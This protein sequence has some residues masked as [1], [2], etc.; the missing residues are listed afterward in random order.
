M[1]TTTERFSYLNV[2]TTRL[3]VKVQKGEV[4]VMRGGHCDDGHTA[5]VVGMR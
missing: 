5:E 3:Q 4:D 2:V 1:M